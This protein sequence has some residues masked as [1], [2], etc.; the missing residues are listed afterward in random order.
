MPGDTRD[1]SEQG[2]LPTY[3]RIAEELT[4]DIGGGRLGEGDKLPPERQMAA[5]FGVAVATLRKALQVLADRGLIDRRQG[6]GNY[7]L[8]GKS[9]VGTYALFRLE[10]N[11]GGGGLPTARLLDMA[12]MTK[13]ADI[14]DIGTTLPFGI[15]MRRLRSLSAEPVALE[16]IWLDGRWHDDN[17]LTPRTISESLYRT[18]EERLFLKIRNVEDRI[19]AAA[20]PDW[21]P[22]DL[23]LAPG[24]MMGYV[25]RRAFDQYGAPCEFSRTWFD[26]TRARYFARVP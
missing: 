7:V 15:R 13:P 8:G 17:G 19:S 21:A 2:A 16:E 3:L 24:H 9:N 22:E 6:S 26:P 23:G 11:P 10:R 12:K 5:D 18:Y 25:E 20:L 1:A 4:I 14:P